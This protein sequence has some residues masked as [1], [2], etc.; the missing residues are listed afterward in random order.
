MT[1]N[2]SRYSPLESLLWSL[3]FSPKQKDH[4]ASSLYF[5][6]PLHPGRNLILS[7]AFSPKK[8]VLVASSTLRYLSI[9]SRISFRVDLEC[10][11]PPCSCYINF[12]LGYSPDGSVLQFGVQPFF[13]IWFFSIWFTCNVALELRFSECELLLLISPSYNPDMRFIPSGVTSFICGKKKKNCM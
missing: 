5:E 13:S 7:H 2:S 8:K 6:F 1:Q 11:T 10:N 12:I 9:P 4:I 3:G